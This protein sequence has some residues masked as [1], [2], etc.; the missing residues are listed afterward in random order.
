KLEAGEYKTI[1]D[2]VGHVKNETERIKKQVWEREKEQL[3]NAIKNRVGEIKKRFPRVNIGD[4]DIDDIV[5]Q[6]Y[7]VGYRG[8]DLARAVIR[9]IEERLSIYGQIPLFPGMRR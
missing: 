4:Q 9:A 2:I 7:S 3:K 6:Y 8:I 1:K 5:E